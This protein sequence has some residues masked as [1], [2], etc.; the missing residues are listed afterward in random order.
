M[1]DTVLG[2]LVPVLLIVSL[3]AGL[4]SGRFLPESFFEGLN[5]LA[6]WVGL[7]SMLFIEIAGARVSGGVALR[8]SAA[9]MATSLVLLVAAMAVGKSLRL[10]TGSLRSFG[11]GSF[12]GNLVYVGL[13]VVLY[14]LP[15]ESEARA[16]VIL[17]LAPT[18]PFFNILSVLVLLRPGTG[19][20]L[21]RLLRVLGELARNPLILSCLLGMAALYL[22][23]HL[24]WA[25][26]RG[27][28]SV[29]QLG[30]PAALLA[31]GASL[32][33]ERVRG[34]GGTAV[35]AA[36]LKVGLTPLVGFFVARACG[37]QGEMLTVCLL[38]LAAPTAVASYVMADQMGADSDLSAAIIVIS[39]LLAFPALA[40][41]LLTFG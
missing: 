25:L 11:Q 41:I 29:G 8:I 31:L 12:R 14:A 16:T 3:G 20:P 6:F 24:P 22:K 32:T 21:R 19:S 30:L 10:P 9:I 33:W 5:R 15:A 39:T 2:A 36:L 35:T 37:L 23:L 34:Q 17:A 7:P 40:V 4:R 27:I 1:W 26:H 13:P 38:Y 18:V 28:A